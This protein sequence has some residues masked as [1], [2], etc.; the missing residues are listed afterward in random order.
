MKSIFWNRAQHGLYVFLSAF[1]LALILSGKIWFWS[2]IFELD[3][4]SDL[5]F[6]QSFG[7][8]SAI[9]LVVDYIFFFRIM[10]IVRRLVA[11][12]TLPWDRIVEGV[13]KAGIKNLGKM[14]EG[15]FILEKNRR[16]A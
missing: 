12:W 15:E 1:L 16:L 5:L 7:V 3:Y 2:W 13:F 8:M 9:F 14:T 4:S 11:E 6:R 10:L